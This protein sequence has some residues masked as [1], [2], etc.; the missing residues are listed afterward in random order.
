LGLVGFGLA[1]IAGCGSFAA[2]G[3]NAEGVRLFQQA[4]YQEA[5]QQFHQAINTDPNNADSYYNLASTYHRMG[6]LNSSQADLKQAEHYYLMCRDRN[7]NHS[8]C[9]RGLAVLM[10][11]QGRSE[12]AFRLL[13]DWAERQP[14]LAEP[15]MELAR[16]Y[17]EFGDVSA[18]KEHLLEALAIDHNNPR[19]EA[20]LGGLREKTGEKAQALENYQRSLALN[21]FQP[22]VAARVA[23]LQGQTGASS[24]ATIVAPPATSTDGTR[25]VTTGTAVRR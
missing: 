1:S 25:T 9:Y 19:I 16:L 18:A 13:E 5:I 10:I 24:R 6:T 7:A 22:E 8:E 17:Q 12:E 3:R 4:R 15:K 2:Q 14:A 20:A 11:Q 23:A 21:R